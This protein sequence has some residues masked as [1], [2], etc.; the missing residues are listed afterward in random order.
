MPSPSSALQ[1]HPALPGPRVLS[2][3]IF[4]RVRQCRHARPSHQAPVGWEGDTAA[5]TVVCTTPSLSPQHC[6]QGC[7]FPSVRKALPTPGDFSA[8]LAGRQT[9]QEEEGLWVQPGSIEAQKPFHKTAPPPSP[10]PDT[11]HHVTL[12]TMPGLSEPQLSHL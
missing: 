9:W 8:Q 5:H 11:F 6:A 12:D 7:G 4:P 1:P 10:G 3:P 2:R